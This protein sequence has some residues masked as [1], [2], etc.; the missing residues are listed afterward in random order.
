MAGDHPI[1]LPLKQG[2][3][4]T[5]GIELDFADVSRASTAF[6]RVVRDMEFDVAE[7][8][9][10]T[11]LMAK[12]L[13]KPLALLPAVLAGRFQHPFLGYNAARGLLAP[14]D[15]AGR[16]VGIRSYSVTTGT[17][18]RGILAHDHGV[19]IDK[20]E[21]ITTDEPHVAEFRDPPN[22]TR[23]SKDKDMATLL[24]EG[25][26]DAAIIGEG[27]PKEDWCKPLIADPAAAAKDWEQR[28]GAMQINHMLV[29]K[30]SLLD[31]NP[32]AV[33]EVW[34]AFAESRRVAVE[35]GAAPLPFG[36]EANR[37]NLEVAIQYAF[38][39]KLIP[40]PMSVD[41]LFTD[42]TRSLA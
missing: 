10:I 9:I 38:E 17:W 31:E 1:T 26:I 13:G 23:I 4:A 27:L 14:S 34:K 18:L 37:R 12:A 29:V 28:N 36:L 19:D 15:L 32:D 20:V 35:A 3:I 25:A 5:P 39:Q 11:F 6:K 42:V 2:K 30:Q 22:V 8:A 21:W 40:R 16:K 33:L 7:L 41:E 24:R